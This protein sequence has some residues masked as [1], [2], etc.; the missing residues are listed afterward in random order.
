VDTTDNFS[1]G[2]E[3][4][5]LKFCG[6]NTS[7]VFSS[8]GLST[9]D[10]KTGVP[11]I[12]PGVGFNGVL[13]APDAV[14]VVIHALASDSHSRVMSA[15]KVLVNDNAT[16]TL[17]SIAEEPF[18]SINVLNT[19][20]TNSFGGYASAGTTITVTPH[21]AEGDHLEINYQLTVSSFTGS[22][23]GTTPPP[24]SSD[25]LSSTIRV[26]DGHTVI[27]G[28]LLTETFAESSSHVPLIGDVPVV[29]WLFG[30]QDH[31][32][33]K[34]RLYAFIRPTILRHEDFED[35]K[36]L[37]GQDRQAAGVDDDYP[38]DRF[39]CMR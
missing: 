12:N 22:G 13:L 10:T 19:V 25:T 15:P 24:R 39:Q 23:T 29:G 5:S 16:A 1:L 6:E 30:T 26:P 18:S 37:S 20:S 4:S 28:G 27:V 31:S 2:V 9:L 36:Y 21:I 7:L 35:L 33:S 32:K 11:A 3:L 8:F 34:V 38:P 14:N 17:S